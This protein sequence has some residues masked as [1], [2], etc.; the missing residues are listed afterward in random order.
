[1]QGVAGSNPVAPILLTRECEPRESPVAE[2]IGDALVAEYHVKRRCVQ[3]L[4]EEGS[5]ASNSR[6]LVTVRRSFGWAAGPSSSV[7]PDGCPRQGAVPHPL[8]LGRRPSHDHHET[9][10]TPRDQVQPVATACDDAKLPQARHLRL[11]QQPVAVTRMTTWTPGGAGGR[12]F[13][14]CRSDH[15]SPRECE[16][17][18]SRG[19]ARRTAMAASSSEVAVGPVADRVAYMCQIRWQSLSMIPEHELR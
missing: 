16:P 10:A 19:L 9:P 15:F 4:G 18:H 5:R 12:R 3:P 13:E 1:V 6:G 7:L 2:P 11:R 8:R 17:R 14:S